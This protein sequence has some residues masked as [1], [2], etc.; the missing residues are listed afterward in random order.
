MKNLHFLKQ[1]VLS[2]SRNPF[3]NKWDR[4]DSLLA[5]VG[6]LVELKNIL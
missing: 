4:E 5:L 6:P 2:V 1:F 3:L